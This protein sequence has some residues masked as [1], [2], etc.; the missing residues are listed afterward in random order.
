MMDENL[1]NTCL[2][3]LPK[4]A[5]LGAQERIRQLWNQEDGV[6]WGLFQ[7]G[8]KEALI[9]LFRKY[10]RH[11]VILV[12]KKM[13]AETGANLL[14]I[15][16]AF[17]DFLEQILDGKYEEGL[18]KNFVAFA[19]HNLSFLLRAH[20]RTTQRRAALRLEHS[21]NFEKST[22]SHLKL[23]HRLDLVRV[24][25]LIPKVTNKVYRMVLYLVFILGYSSGDL[26]EVFG[27][28]ER[29][30]D[31]R[32]RAMKAFRELLEREGILQELR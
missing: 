27:K 2:G 21:S 25:D 9:V 30:Y 6:L 1:K 15:E 4:F 3:L 26:V 16:D 13:N 10:H 14:D 8:C 19:V 12:Y 24:I 20:A 7:L 17:S 5:P 28:K 11:I 29:A 32:S 31:K 23:E 22:R 18:R